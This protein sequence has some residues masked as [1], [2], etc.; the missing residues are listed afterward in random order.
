MSSID[1]TFNC[2]G[3]TVAD[4]RKVY[5]TELSKELMYAKIPAYT[6][7]PNIIPCETMTAERE[8]GEN[9]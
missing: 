1:T 8:K 4:I 6:F 7:Y 5:V 9:T 3:L 2:Y